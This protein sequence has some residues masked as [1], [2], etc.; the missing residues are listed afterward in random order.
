MKPVKEREEEK[1]EEA[2]LTTSDL[3]RT[4]F[5][6]GYM[7]RKLTRSLSGAHVSHCQLVLLG[8]RVVCSTDGE[9]SHL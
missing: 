9:P 4:L 8:T 6:G 1:R 7:L 3:W 2:L 5:R